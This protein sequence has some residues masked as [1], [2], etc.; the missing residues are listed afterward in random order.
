MLKDAV[1]TVMKLAIDTDYPHLKLPAV[2]F[3]RVVSA[4]K[5]GTYDTEGLTITDETGGESFAARIKADLYEYRLEVTDRFGNA[6]PAF[7]ALPGIRS[8]K[9]FQAGDLAVVAF[10]YGD[11]D[12]VIIGE[13]DR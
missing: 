4:R 8:R 9:Q 13:A 5:C 3:A 10:P 7:P 1:R 11:T 6:D 12:P 2:M